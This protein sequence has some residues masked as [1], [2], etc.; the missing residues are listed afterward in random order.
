[1]L[2]SYHFLPGGWHLFVGGG[3]EFFAHAKGGGLD[4]IG[5][6]RSQTMAI[7]GHSN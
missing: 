7:A 1:M 6:R 4:K 5:N 3:P 2:G